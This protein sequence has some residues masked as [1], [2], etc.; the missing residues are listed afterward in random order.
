MLSSKIEY[1][2]KPNIFNREYHFY[3]ENC[4]VIYNTQETTPGTEE[5]LNIIFQ[6]SSL[7]FSSSGDMSSI[8]VWLV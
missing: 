8:S 5:L 4:A 6:V 7:R 3:Q 1:D 2:S